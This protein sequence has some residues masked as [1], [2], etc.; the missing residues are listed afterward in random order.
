VSK[1]CCLACLELLAVLND[2][3]NDSVA[4]RG[5]HGTVFPME[6]PSWLPVA[7]LQEMVTRFKGHLFSALKELLMIHSRPKVS[8]LI[9]HANHTYTDNPGSKNHPPLL[10]YSTL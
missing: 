3:G 9:Q 2:G 10:Q 8:P 4:V 5:C 1:P 6:L 7:V